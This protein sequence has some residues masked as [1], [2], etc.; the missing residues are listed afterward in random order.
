[1][2]T[3]FPFYTNLNDNSRA[4][5]CRDISKQRA[6]A[7]SVLPQSYKVS[8]NPSRN[9]VKQ[10][11]AMWFIVHNFADYRVTLAFSSGKYIKY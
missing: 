1:M 6:R 9:R 8:K 2:S 11:H 4:N 3:K 10:K 7:F 5:N